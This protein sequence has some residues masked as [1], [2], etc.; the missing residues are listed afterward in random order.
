MNRGTFSQT[1]TI[2]SIYL[3]LIPELDIP[4]LINICY[5]TSFKK[6]SCFLEMI[7]IYSLCP[8]PLKSKA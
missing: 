7:Q 3:N 2:R 5:V 8:F 6:K 4:P 1:F